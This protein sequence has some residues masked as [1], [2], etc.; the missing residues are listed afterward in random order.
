MHYTG[1]LDSLKQ[2]FENLKGSDA[3]ADLSRVARAIYAC[4]LPRHPLL[5]DAIKCFAEHWAS[6]KNKTA[7]MAGK[8][9]TDL[10]SDLAQLGV[11][12]I[13][14]VFRVVDEYLLENIEDAYALL[15][16]VS[17]QDLQE[18]WSNA[19]L[20]LSRI[21]APLPHTHAPILLV[22]MLRVAEAK[23]CMNGIKRLVA[24]SPDLAQFVVNAMT[25]FANRGDVVSLAYTAGLYAYCGNELTGFHYIDLYVRSAR[26]AVSAHRALGA[27]VFLVVK[28]DGTCGVCLEPSRTSMNLLCG[29]YFCSMCGINALLRKPACPLCRTQIY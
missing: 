12:T 22:K 8:V 20:Y 18:F 6:Q 14:A 17:N 29:H 7:N 23:D 11:M 3:P 1:N 10:D 9:L 19:G 4:I 24:A 13:S 15:G 27:V 21:L 2:M 28:K 16:L 5:L 26:E 25:V